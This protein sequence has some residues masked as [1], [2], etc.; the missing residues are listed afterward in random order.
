MAL[1]DFMMEKFGA[2]QTAQSY[3]SILGSLAASPADIQNQQQQSLLTQIMNSQDLSQQQKLEALSQASPQF[4][5]KRMELM[6]QPPKPLNAPNVQ[7]N[8]ATGELM[9]TQ[10]DPNT[11]QL[12]MNG[13]PQGYGQQPQQ[14]NQNNM[15]GMSD[16]MAGMTPKAR[17]E[18]QAE[19][20]KEMAAKES[21]RPKAQASLNSAIAQADRMV[22]SIQ[23]LKEQA[24]DPSATGF[25]GQILR[26]I[27]G[28]KAADLAANTTVADANNFINALAELK[29]NS[30]TGAS[31]LGSLT[32][33][34]GQKIQSLIANLDTTQSAP[35]LQKQYDNLAKELLASKERVQRAFDD[36]YG[37]SEAGGSATPP[38]A[39][40]RK[41]PD[42]NFYVEQNGKFFKVVQ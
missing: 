29:S 33:R 11:G 20:A 42:G 30:P 28:T 10:Y 15:G 16:P 5:Q 19:R 31:G 21:M 13:A 41:A 36:Y 18:Y 37:A 22:G 40:A 32:E 38:I 34:E 26:Y 27:G 9:I 23:S 35:Q 17:S 25:A 4:A 2:P 1:L 12:T 8:P 14:P 24:K 7:F 6:L 3:R 39:G